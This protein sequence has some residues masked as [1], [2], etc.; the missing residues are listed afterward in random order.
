M[1]ARWGTAVTGE[2]YVRGRPPRPEP[3]TCADAFRSRLLA[4]AAM[5]G[6]SNGPLRPLRVAFQPFGGTGWLGGRHYLTTLLAALHEHAAAEVEPVL[7]VPAAAD[8]E[9]VAGLRPFLRTDPI[10]MPPTEGVRAWA[11][12]AVGDGLARRSAALE[13]TCRGAGIDVVYQHAEW[14]GS[15][16]EIP[17]LA[18]LGDFQHRVLPE[19]FGRQLRWRRELRFQAVLRSATLLYVLSES[20]RELG[21]RFYPRFSP[22]LRALPFAVHVPPDALLADPVDTRIRY[23]LPQKFF[24]FPG[25]QWRHKNHLGVIEAV[26]MLKRAGEEVVVAFC[27]NP[28]DHRDAGHGPT[29]AARRSELRV[30]EQ[31]RLLGVVPRQDVWALLRASAA[32]INP[33][34]YEGWSTP[35]EEAKSIG[36]PLLL[37]DIPAHREQR[38]PQTTFFDPSDSTSIAGALGS[39]W[40]RHPAGPRP[41]AER[42]AAEVL[43]PRQRAFAQN[44]VALAREAAAGE[45]SA[46]PSNSA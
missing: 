12:Q 21:N 31:V 34:L 33:S 23:G 25:Q 35:V 6:G 37:S 43:A 2:G 22:K 9:V 28:V 16:F 24:V 41:E 18:W 13:T 45:G 3:L 11:V 44:F 4:S 32:V 29:V 19:M 38:P 39:G 7:I 8:A 20:D 14:L 15:R 10:V 1:L 46:E 27:G 26:A 42:N 40:A 5:S 17:T 30:E 36:A